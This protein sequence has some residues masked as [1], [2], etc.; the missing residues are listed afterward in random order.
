MHHR[1]MFIDFINGDFG[2]VRERPYELLGRLFHAERLSRR[3]EDERQFY[4]SI[5]LEL[6]LNRGLKVGLEAAHS[7]LINCWM[8]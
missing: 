6:I 4:R 3:Q 1:I 2:P 8:V 5:G 7:S